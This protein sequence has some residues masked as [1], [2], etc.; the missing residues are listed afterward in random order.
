M[1]AVDCPA[2][3][4]VATALTVAG[5]DDKASIIIWVLRASRARERPRTAGWA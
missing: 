3:P 2:N 5:G 4:P 1:D